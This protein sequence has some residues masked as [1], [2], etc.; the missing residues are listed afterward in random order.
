MFD[1]GGGEFLVIA[2]VALIA[3]GPKELPGVLRMVGQWVGK[4][5]GMARDFQNQFQEAMREADVA[6]M[7]RQFDETVESATNP[8]KS[9]LGS[10]TQDITDAFKL[11]PTP[12]AETRIEPADIAATTPTPTSEQAPAPAVESAPI[13][14]VDPQQIPGPAPDAVSAGKPS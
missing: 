12:Q 4:A 9:L 1:I 11:A 13:D 10:T 2:I 6:E 8:S 7:K 3:I 14:P 5:R